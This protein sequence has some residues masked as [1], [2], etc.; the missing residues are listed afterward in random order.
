M[1]SEYAVVAAYAAGEEPPP[2]AFMGRSHPNASAPHQ[3]RRGQHT[4]QG[5][6]DG[7][8]LGEFV[9]NEQL[10]VVDDLEVAAAA[11]AA[12]MEALDDEPSSTDSDESSD[13]SDAD[14]SMGDHGESG[15]SS[16]SGSGSDSDAATMEVEP[17]AVS[18]ELAS[19]EPTSVG[20][21]LTLSGGQQQPREQSNAGNFSG[22]RVKLR[23]EGDAE[24]ALELLL[25]NST[26][27][28]AP[29]HA[30]GAQ[31]AQQVDDLAVQQEAPGGSGLHLGL[32]EHEEEEEESEDE[33][34]DDSDEEITDLAQIRE[35]INAFDEDDEVCA[36]S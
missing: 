18:A 20:P 17:A 25:A 26:G 31:Q 27:G 30:A 12:A 36:R 6:L 9:V 3:A 5:Q 21:P 13:D 32:V 2:Q 15:A 34:S 10:P 7:E 35:I 23:I 8:D 28:E 22:V 19:E 24:V 11:A 29:M 4:S 16:G 1:N 14:D 33:S